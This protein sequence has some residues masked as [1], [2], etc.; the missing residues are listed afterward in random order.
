MSDYS[1]AV[2]D[3][4]RLHM[5]LHQIRSASWTSVSPDAG[6]TLA[7]RNARNREALRDIARFAILALLADPVVAEEFTAALDS[8]EKGGCHAG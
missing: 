1:K 4:V 2:A 6:G 8:A 3:G 7:E 5:A